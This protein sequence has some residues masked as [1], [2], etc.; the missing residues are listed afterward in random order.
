MPRANINSFGGPMNRRVR[1]ATFIMTLVLVLQL[2]P[3]RVNAATDEDFWKSMSTSFYYDQLGS[4]EKKLYDRI[5]SF[6]ME[7]LLSDKTYSKS[8][9]FIQ[10]TEFGLTRDQA[11]KVFLI[12]L[13][14]NPQIYFIQQRYAYSS[15]KFGFLVADEFL[16]GQTRA[17][18]TSRFKEA[19]L[20]YNNTAA[21]R[22]SGNLPEQIEKSFH[23]VIVE[24]TDYVGNDYDQ[25]PISLVLNHQTVC[26]GYARSFQL[27]MNMN[28][29]DCIMVTNKNHAWNAINLHG[30]WYIVDCTNDDQSWGM[31]LR[32]YNTSTAFWCP[33]VTEVHTQT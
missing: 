27:F 18:Y 10:F 3:I 15:T 28:K 26:T 24:T 17:G 12:Y 7:M 6:C 32:F 16:D 11:E 14:S 20:D 30:E 22:R 19:I 33:A 4:A 2:L 23:D 1:L 9:G 29:V 21:A 25:L 5:D 8:A 13:H 31:T